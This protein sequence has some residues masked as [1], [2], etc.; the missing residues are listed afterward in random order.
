MLLLLEP[1]KKAEAL[2]P[3][4]A[5]WC[6]LVRSTGRERQPK[7]LDAVIKDLGT[8]PPA[9]QPSKSALWVAGLINPLPALGVALEIRPA[10]LMAQTA[11]LRLQVAARTRP[12]GRHAL[13]A[14]ELLCLSIH[15]LWAPRIASRWY[16]RVAAFQCYQYAY[17]MILSHNSASF[18]LRLLTWENGNHASNHGHDCRWRNKERYCD[19]TE[20]ISIVFSSLP[21]AERD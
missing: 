6:E 12:R 15:M 19:S 13:E 5:E 8:L 18:H 16:N 3:I 2:E 11:E 10:A 17:Q 20:L 4:I 1:A 9:T 21:A 14:V 7:Q